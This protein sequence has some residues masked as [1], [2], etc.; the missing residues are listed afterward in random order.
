MICLE[1]RGCFIPWN[2]NWRTIWQRIIF[3]NSDN[4]TRVHKNAQ[5]SSGC[6]IFIINLPLL[7]LSKL[8]KVLELYIGYFSEALTV[9]G[10]YLSQSMSNN[11]K[12]LLK[13]DCWYKYQNLPQTRHKEQNFPPAQGRGA[14]TFSGLWVRRTL[15]KVGN[16]LKNQVRENMTKIPTD[17]DKTNMST[18]TF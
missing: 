16:V 12:I 15:N 2:G 13:L 1:F 4:Q 18:A 5:P 7:R 14:V 10:L 3:T 6:Q 17:V 11:M 8:A 9:N